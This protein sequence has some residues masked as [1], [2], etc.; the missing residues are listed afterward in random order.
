MLTAVMFI[1]P[2]QQTIAL[3]NALLFF[4]LVWVIVGLVRLPQV[5]RWP[6]EVPWVVWGVFAVLTV[7]MYLQAFG[8]ALAPDKVLT[9]IRARWLLNLIVFFIGVSAARLL[10]DHRQTLIRL[11]FAMLAV[12]VWFIVGVDIVHWVQHGWLM[13]RF[14]GLEGTDFLSISGSPDKANY[15]TDMYLALLFAE[16]IMKRLGRAGVLG[17]GYPFIGVLFAGGLFS[18]YAEDMR[19]GTVLLGLMT[20]LSIGVL[21]SQSPPARRRREIMVATIVGI[22]GI[23][24]VSYTLVHQQRWR[25]LLATVP[26]ALDTSHNREWLTGGLPKFP[27][28]QTVNVSNYQRIAWAKEGLHVIWHY[29]LGVGFQGQAFGYGVDAIYHTDLAR[30][31][32]SHS[33]II[34]FTDGVGLPGLVLWLIFIGTLFRKAWTGLAYERLAPAAALGM[35]VFDYFTRSLVDSI[36]RDHMWQMFMF[37]SGFLLSWTCLLSARGKQPAD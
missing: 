16:V 1:W 15:L 28:G 37:M 24:F 6:R 11:L 5:D 34:D 23:G 14:G 32:H 30:G 31:N 9:E 2:I 3:R 18:A 19:N 12:N 4:A 21:I 26:I 22:L 25:T 29:P 36:M 13:R 35:V 7:W 8:W 10:P 17:F 27:D 33:G 20:L